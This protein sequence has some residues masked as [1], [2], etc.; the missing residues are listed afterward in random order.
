MHKHTCPKVVHSLSPPGFQPFLMPINKW[1]VINPISHFR[2]VDS[3]R[4]GF[5]NP[6][7]AVVSV[8]VIE[9]EDSQG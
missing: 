7:V 8:C 2:G 6:A 3:T 9:V 4:T 5:T 1:K